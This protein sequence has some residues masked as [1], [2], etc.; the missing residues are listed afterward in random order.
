MLE[1]EPLVKFYMDIETNIREK[2]FGHMAMQELIGIKKITFGMGRCSGDEYVFSELHVILPTIIKPK[3]IILS[4]IPLGKE[5]EPK[6]GDRCI[7]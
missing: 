6:S 3:C 4:P 5:N 1:K 7:R 2:S